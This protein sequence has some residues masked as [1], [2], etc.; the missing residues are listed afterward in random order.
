L[1]GVLLFGGIVWRAHYRRHGAGFD[2]PKIFR[3]R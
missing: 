3:N 2:R 1:I